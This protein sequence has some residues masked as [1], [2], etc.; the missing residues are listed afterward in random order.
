MKD[1]FFLCVQLHELPHNLE[2]P[3]RRDQGRGEWGCVPAGVQGGVGLSLLHLGQVGAMHRSTGTPGN[4][5]QGQL[6]WWEELDCHYFTWVRCV[7]VCI[8]V[9]VKLMS[10]T[11]SGSGGFKHTYTGAPGNGSEFQ[12]LCTGR[13]W[14]VTTSPG[15]GGALTPQ[16]SQVPVNI[17]DLLRSWDSRPRA[18]YSARATRLRIVDSSAS[19]QY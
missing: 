9:H 11:A 4:G 19:I 2:Q 3:G 15:S 10:A 12:L 16:K 6:A 18:T 17:S 5:P 14:A 13:F 8:K 1:I 7:Q